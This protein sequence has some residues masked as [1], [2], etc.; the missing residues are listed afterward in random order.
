M[1]FKQPIFKGV[2]A[3]LTGF[4]L[5]SL[6]ILFKCVTKCITPGKVS[7]KGQKEIAL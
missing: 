3:K 2:P 4:I 7:S 1:F 5:F 6:N